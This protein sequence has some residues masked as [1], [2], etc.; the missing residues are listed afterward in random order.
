M[1]HPAIAAL[2][3][4]VGDALAEPKGAAR[5]HQVVLALGAGILD[6]VGIAELVRVDQ[7]RLG[8]RD[9]VVECER[10]DQPRRGVVDR[11]KPLAP[12]WRASSLHIGAKL[13]QHAIEQG[14]PL[15]GMAARTGREQIGDALRNPSAFV[16]TRGERGIS[17][18]ISDFVVLP[19]SA[20]AASGMGLPVGR[21]WDAFVGFAQRSSCR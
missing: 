11:G 14:D 7:H 10:T 13:L 8:H 21:Q 6:Q 3:Q 18:S 15:T 4:N 2:D 9:G 5:W 20:V 1:D 17:L 19:K 16:H 12:I